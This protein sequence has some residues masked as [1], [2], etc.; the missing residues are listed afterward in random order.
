MT[1]GI[2]RARLAAAALVMAMASCLQLQDAAAQSLDGQYAF[3]LTAKCARLNFDRFEGELS[4][5]V[6]PGQA[7][8]ELDAFCSG[9]PPVGGG[10]DASSASTGTAGNV[11]RG[12]DEALRRR[13]SEARGDDAAGA[14]EFSILSTGLTSLFAS[15]NYAHEDQ[16]MR[17]F[18]GGRRADL[19][20]LT[21]GLDRKLGDSGLI[22][23][24]AGIEDQ[25]GDLD[26]GGTS[27]NRG[28]SALLYGSWMPVPALFLDLNGGVTFRKADSSRSVSFTRTLDSGSGPRVIESIAPARANSKVDQLE[29]RAALLAGYDIGIGATSFGP[30]LAVEYRRNA[31]DGTAETGVSPMAL[32]IDKQVEASLRSGLGAQASHVVNTGS[33]VYVVQLNADWWHEFEDNQRDIDARFAQDLRDEP[34]RFRFQN[35]PPDRDVFTARASLAVTMPRGFS[36]FGSVDG[37]VGHSYLSRYGAAL[38]LRKEL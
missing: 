29:S 11:G 24:A 10:T 31:I 7:G 36:V 14:G 2:P 19:L 37:L 28:Y 35:Q 30:R 1:T 5:D 25:S 22:G 6:V 15:V 8:P 17:R 20:A 23:A 32:V 26:A 18:E 4:N 3:Y 21:L 38:G 33:A 9:L 27:D 12:G 34:V 13:Q 16:K